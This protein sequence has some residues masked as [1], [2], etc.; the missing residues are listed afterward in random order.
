MGSGPEAFGGCD[1]GISAGEGELL[2]PGLEALGGCDSG[3]SAGEG[4]TVDSRPSVLGGWDGDTSLDCAFELPLAVVTISGTGTG[5]GGGSD[6]GGGA[7]GSTT[8]VAPLGEEIP[9][10]TCICLS[11]NPT[12]RHGFGNTHARVIIDR[13]TPRQRE[14]ACGRSFSLDHILFL[15]SDL[16]LLPFEILQGRN[17]GVKYPRRGPF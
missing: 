4:E 12:S 1:S 10:G 3:A 15:P 17:P 14:P 16:V 8:L 5:T 11:G 2:G 6:A 9:D 13:E 7:R